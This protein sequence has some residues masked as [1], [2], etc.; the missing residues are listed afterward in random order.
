MLRTTLLAATLFLAP[1]AAFAWD[2]HRG[3]YVVDADPR[4]AVSIGAPRSGFSLYYQSGGYG[5]VPAAPVY[6]R[7]PV[8][9]R[10]PYYPAHRVHYYPP[11]RHYWHGGARQY[12]N[13]DRHGHGHGHHD[14]DD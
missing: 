4:I 11:A 9:V 8:V 14:R 1:V 5:Y 2:G 12:C 10:T 7:A 3:G 6:Y 13:D